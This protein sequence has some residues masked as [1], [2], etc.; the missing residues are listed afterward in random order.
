MTRFARAKGSKSSNSKIEEDATDWSQLKPQ[1]NQLK[2]NPKPE[3]SSLVKKTIKQIKEG[4]APKSTGWADFGTS[5]TQASQAFRDGGE[6]GA[7]KKKLKKHDQTNKLEGFSQSAVTASQPDQFKRKNIDISN[8]EGEKP[9]KKK[10]KKLDKLNKSEDPSQSEEPTSQPHVLKRK[11]TESFNNEGEPKAKMKKQKKLDTFNKSE[12]LSQTEESTSQPN[13][14]KRKYTEVSNGD[15]EHGA[16]KKNKRNKSKKLIQSAGLKSENKQSQ[17]TPAQKEKIARRKK[18]KMMKKAL[19][20]QQE[21]GVSKEKTPPEE[22]ENGDSGEKKPSEE[23]KMKKADEKKKQKNGVFKRRKPLEGVHTIHINGISINITKFDG[24]DVKQEDALR[25]EE[26]RKKMFESGIPKAEVDIAIKR[27]RRIAEKALAKAK[28]RVCLVC[29]QSGHD[30]S[31][32]PELGS[33]NGETS[34]TSTIC[35]KCGSTEHTHFQCQVQ[36]EKKY[37]F[38]TCFICKEQGHISSQCPSNPKGV[39]P[40][41]GSCLNCGAVTHLRKDCPKNEEKKSENTLTLETL[42]S[43]SNVESLGTSEDHPKTAKTSSAPK[44]AK[45]VKF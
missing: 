20:I 34:G 19:L 41:G 5:G 2:V 40:K 21:K 32:C 14:L 27:E 25:L 6:K 43:T 37:S 4:V 8:G 30:L 26:M 39:Y 24:F 13:E 12:D 31:A 18:Q 23:N 7:K 45:V 36:K 44:K 33:K 38:A 1:A 22:Q 17:K 29:R 16:K 3:T 15:G 9:K 28:K 35:Y 42:S 10:Q 11:S